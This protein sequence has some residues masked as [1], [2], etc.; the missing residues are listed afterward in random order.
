MPHLFQ[1]MAF[2]YLT[3]VT[4]NQHIQCLLYSQDLRREQT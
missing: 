4:H 3:A 1:T 2:Q